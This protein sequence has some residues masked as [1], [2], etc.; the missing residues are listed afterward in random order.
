[1]DDLKNPAVLAVPLYFALIWWE[2]RALTRLKAAGKDV[3]GY[4]RRDTWASLL[5][6]A[7]SLI[8]VGG[9]NLVVK[10]LSE[11]LW[12]YRLTD[13]GNGVLGWTVALLG[14]DFAYYW[15][16]RVEH[17]SRILWSAHV[18]HHSSERYNLST[19]LR[20]PWT[21][22]VLVLFFPP[23][24]LIG[25]RPWMIAVSGGFNLVY[26]FWIHTEAVDKLPRW[27]EFVFN[28]PSHHRVHHGSQ[29]QYLDRNHGGVLIIWDRLFGTFE[30]EGERVR[31]GLTKNINTF[32][33]WKI[34]DHELVAIGRDVKAASRW[35]DRFGYVFFGPGWRPAAAIAAESVDRAA[36]HGSVRTSR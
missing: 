35:R 15:L 14:W 1:M 7:V 4:E 22:V 36:V 8:T 31:Y 11:W 6:G 17:E 10:I 3:L 9:L 19:A 12:D 18:N 27:F 16:H 23:L 25:V 34:F 21:P 29:Q 32:N 33:L 5:I 20:Q 2:V 24:A 13:L 26:Q 28:T 30:P